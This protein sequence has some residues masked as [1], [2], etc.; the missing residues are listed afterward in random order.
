[1]GDIDSII[2]LCLLV[3]LPKFQEEITDHGLNN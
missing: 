3:D 1:M 2:G